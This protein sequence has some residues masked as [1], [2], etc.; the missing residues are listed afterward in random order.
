MI[1]MNFRTSSWVKLAPFFPETLPR[2]IIGDTGGRMEPEELLARFQG[3]NED[4]V[5]MDDDDECHNSEDDGAVD[6]EGCA[7]VR[8]DLHLCCKT[9]DL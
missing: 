4:S 1:T 6:D 8:A 5:G 2:D 9:T 3:E 7:T